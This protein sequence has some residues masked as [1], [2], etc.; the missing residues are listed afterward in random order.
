[1][2]I[3]NRTLDVC[4]RSRLNRDTLLLDVSIDINEMLPKHLIIKFIYGQNWISIG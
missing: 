4:N 1:M 2:G 3:C